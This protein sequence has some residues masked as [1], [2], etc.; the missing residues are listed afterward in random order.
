M[1]D[2][3]ATIV[4]D[5]AECMKRV[6]ARCPQAANLRSGQTFQPGIGP[7]SETQTVALVARELEV[8]APERYADQ[9]GVG[10]PYPEYPRQKCDLCILRGQIWGWAVE[11]KMLRM[12]GDNGKVNDNILMHIL[13]P[14]SEH[15]SA[16]TDCLKLAQSRLAHRRA[17]LIYGY[18]HHQWP[19]EP[20]IEAFE[21]LATT[22]VS[23]GGR[24]TARLGGLIHPVHSSGAVFAWEVEQQTL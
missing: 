14:Y 22:K 17:I 3:L 6:D 18:E 2:D 23:L 4:N 5:F 16:L 13:S 1:V 9:I 19:L 15:R 7:H 10:R 20:A 11:V 12:L 21:A 8:Y 24:Q